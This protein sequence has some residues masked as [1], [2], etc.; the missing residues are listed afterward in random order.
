MLRVLSLL[1]PVG[2][3]VLAGLL[4]TMVEARCQGVRVARRTV[5]T[6]AALTA[7]CIATAVYL[8]GTLSGFELFDDELCQSLEAGKFVSHR[9]FTLPLSEVV[10]CSEQTVELVPFWVNPALAVLLTAALGFA[11]MALA[12][13]RRRP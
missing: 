1:C 10:E 7:L 4:F 3:F 8:F 6:A 13:W 5:F 9:S 2:I 12:S 11:A